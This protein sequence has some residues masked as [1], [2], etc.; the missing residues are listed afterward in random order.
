MVGL[1]FVEIG[2]PHFSELLEILDSGAHVG[3]RKHTAKP[4]QFA[5]HPLSKLGEGR[6]LHGIGNEPQEPVAT[7]TMALSNR[8]DPM[9]QVVN[10]LFMRG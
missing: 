8:L 3:Q 10:R 7:A 6:R 1:D 4:C 2:E 5:V 9:S